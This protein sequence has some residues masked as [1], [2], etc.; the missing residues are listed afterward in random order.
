D[1]YVTAA[2]V[3]SLWAFDRLLRRPGWGAVAA[4][5]V[6]LGAAGLAKFTGLLLFLL[7]P[8]I[9]AGLHLAGRWRPS[10]LEATPWRRR[11]LALA[12]ALA[13]GV[14]VI[15]LGY[16]CDGSLTALGEFRFSTP[17]FQRLQAA[18]PGWL[19]VPLPR[20]FFQGMDAQLAEQDYTAYLLGEFNETGF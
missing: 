17:P 3:G 12:G 15:N 8:L 9:L 20:S 10:E 7:F 16:L 6:A 4:L 5:G 13:V 1:I 18:L 2:I 14:L 11:W 19:P